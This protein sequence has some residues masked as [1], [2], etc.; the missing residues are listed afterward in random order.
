MA[1][2]SPLAHNEKRPPEG[3]R[4]TGDA[5]PGGV[6]P[7]GNPLDEAPPPHSVSP[8]RVIAYI[9]GFNLYNGLKA[10]SWRRYMWVDLE[11]LASNLLKSDQ[12]LVAVKYFT[13]RVS[14]PEDSVR[15][16]AAFIDANRSKRQVTVIE[17]RFQAK[18]VTCRSCSNGWTSYEEKHTDVN[19]AVEL[20]S[21]AYENRFDVA[22]V[23]SGDADLTAPVRRANGM[24]GRRVIVVCPP[25]RR[26]DE[27]CK[28]AAASMTLGRGRLAEAQLPDVVEL[29]NG[30]QLVRPH[31]WRE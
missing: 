30:L 6:V 21:D 14:G 31:R 19:I 22:L 12:V 17:G 2:P 11:A 8:L 5:I 25:A 1:D 3:G 10:K 9:D 13:A 18:A 16:Q 4:L 29:R 26:S 28:A 15:R 27:L 24:P 20:V 23:V 7:D